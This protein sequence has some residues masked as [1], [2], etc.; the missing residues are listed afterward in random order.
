MPD[1]MTY[2]KMVELGF[3]NMYESKPQEEGEYEVMCKAGH[4][5]IVK[6]HVIHI[7]TEKCWR[8]TVPERCGWSFG[9]WRERRR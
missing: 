9:W 3:T 2:D 1:G 8:W 6:Y 7:G 5:H 4:I